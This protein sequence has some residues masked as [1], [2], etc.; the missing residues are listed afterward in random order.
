MK[1]ATL[2]VLS[3]LIFLSTSGFS[4]VVKYC[5]IKKKTSF[6]FNFKKSCCAKKGK[7]CCKHKQVV[8]E[9]IKDPVFEKNEIKFI[10]NNNSD[11]FSVYF[12]L[13]KLK[14]TNTHYFGNIDFTSS[15]VKQNK[16]LILLYRVMI[17]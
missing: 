14:F 15:K 8:F 9:K 4:V 7:K 13:S 16:P 1:K 6:S 3:F 12:Y 10:D 2:I 17:I 5:P 11:F